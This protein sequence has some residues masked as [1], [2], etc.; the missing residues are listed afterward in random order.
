MV[1]FTSLLGNCNW[2]SKPRDLV[3]LL[4]DL[5]HKKSWRKDKCQSLGGFLISILVGHSESLNVKKLKLKRN[6]REKNKGL[7]MRNV[8]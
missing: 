4:E 2:A 5:G 1:H 6:L 7:R 3:S 8:D